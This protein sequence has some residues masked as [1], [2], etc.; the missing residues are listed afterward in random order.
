MMCALVVRRLKPESYDAFRAAW[1][2]EGDDPWHPGLVKV[3]MAR[4]DDDPDVV[5]T[6]TLLD[7][8][9]DEL[10]E[11]RDD[12]RWLASDAHRQPRMAELEEELILASYFEV[13]DELIP[14]GR[15]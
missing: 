2:P 3:Y 13:T 6:W 8:G 1:V 9:P 10:D 4:S 15:R 12:P 14:P 11:A 7:L 5:A